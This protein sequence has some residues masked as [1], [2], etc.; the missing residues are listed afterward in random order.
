M[1]QHIRYPTKR[2]K[3]EIVDRLAGAGVPETEIHAAIALARTGRSDLL[4]RVIAGEIDIARARRL[5]RSP[6]QP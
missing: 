2:A 3:T 6:Q 5:A 1:T 4:A